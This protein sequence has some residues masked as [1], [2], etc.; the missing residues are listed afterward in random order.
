[1][2][3]NSGR[4]QTEGDVHEGDGVSSQ[5]IRCPCICQHEHCCQQASGIRVPTCWEEID[6]PEAD[7]KGGTWAFGTHA[8]TRADLQVHSDL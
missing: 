5:P 7:I 8:N 4:R 6:N 3:K 1:M 2:A